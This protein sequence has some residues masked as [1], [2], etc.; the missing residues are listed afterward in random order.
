MY[1]KILVPLDGT[2]NDEVVLEHVQRLAKEMGAA[3]ILIQ[4]YRVVKDDDPFMR[5]VQMEVGS[6]GYQAEE[7]AKGYLRELEESIGQK[8]I[9]VSSEFLMVETPEA[10][11]IVKYAEEKGCHLIALTN[12]EKTGFGRWFFSNIEEKVKRRSPL[13]ILLV[14]RSKK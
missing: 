11:E 9:A 4:L 7:K 8:G 3:L 1:K 6:Q 14:A 5:S 2:K 13:P 10:D 12:Q